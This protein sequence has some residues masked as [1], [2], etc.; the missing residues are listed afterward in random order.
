MESLGTNTNTLTMAMTKL[1]NTHTNTQKTSLSEQITKFLLCRLSLSWQ[2]NNNDQI[3]K[4]CH[5]E[6]E[7]MIFLVNFLL[8]FFYLEDIPRQQSQLL[9]SMDIMLE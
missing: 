7:Q 9:S 6:S 1:K 2:N 3:Q 5:G 4:L 8:P